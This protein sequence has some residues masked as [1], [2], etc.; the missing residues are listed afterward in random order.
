MATPNNGSLMDRNVPS[1]LDNEDLAA[2]M[3]LEIPQSGEL[4]IML[5]ESDNDVMAMFSGSGVG[6][7]EISPTEDGGVERSA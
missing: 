2:E 3:A 6:E 1:Q 7:I 5:P 4:D